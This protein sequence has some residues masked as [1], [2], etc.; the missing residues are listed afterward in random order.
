[1]NSQ[2]SRFLTDIDMRLV[3]LK[4]SCKST[5]SIRTSA[6]DLMYRVA[7]IFLLQSTGGGAEQRSQGPD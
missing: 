5:D 4:D 3:A 7:A 6:E 1:M 2:C